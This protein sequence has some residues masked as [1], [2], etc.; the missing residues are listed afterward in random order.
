M[1]YAWIGAAFV[2]LTLGLLGSGGSILTVPVLTY[3]VGRPDK[4]AIAESL[5]IVGVIALAGALPHLRAGRVD[6]RTVLLF[7]LPGLVGAFGG[8]TLARYVP[9]AVQLLIFAVVMLAASYAML[10]GGPQKDR[11][12]RSAATAAAAGLFVGVLTGLVGVGGGFLIVPALVMLVGL[13]MRRAVATSLVVIALN[14][15]VGFVRYLGTLAD[16]GLH[17]DLRLIG[18]FALI[19]VVGVYAGGW[20]GTRV[21]QEQLRRL[22][23]FFLIGMGMFILWQEGSTLLRG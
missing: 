20:L 17:P 14:S 3:L 4:L 19:G 10:R 18:T 7:G 13:D 21:P 16:V 11:V 6:G 8:A 22:F 23:A 2:G 5:A 9:G 12:P 1:F 15:A